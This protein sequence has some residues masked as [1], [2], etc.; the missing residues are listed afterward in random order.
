MM[1]HV[2]IALTLSLTVLST[3]VQSDAAAYVESYRLLPRK[4]ELTQ[5]GGFAGVSNH[6]RL[7][8]DYDFVRALPDDLPPG[9]SRSTAQFDDAN[10]Y[11]SLGP[12]LP[13]FIASITY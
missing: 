6:Y 4:S 2:L 13:A 3:P 7:H 1:R 12:M 11:A 5:T 9:Q 10:V 8:G